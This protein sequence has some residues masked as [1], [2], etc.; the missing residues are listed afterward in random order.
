M[1]TRDGVNDDYSTALDPYS[2][3]RGVRAATNGKT[4]QH[5]ADE[6]DDTDLFAQIAERIESADV[7]AGQPTEEVLWDVDGLMPSD[8][9]PAHMFGPPGAYKSWLGLHLC[10]AIVRGAKFLDR[11]IVRK[12][13]CALYINVDAGPKTFRNRVRR[14]SDSAAFDFISLTSAEFSQLDRRKLFERYRGGFIAID[15]LAAIYNPAKDLDP[16]FAMRQFVDDLRADY[17]QFDCGGVIIDHPHRP[18][19]KGTEGDFYG[20]VQKQAGFRTMWQIS[21]KTGGSDAAENCRTQISCR[22]L[23]EGQDFAAVE[24]VIDFS[25]EPVAFSTTNTEPAS[26]ENAI[27]AKLIA[28]A[29]EQAKTFS[30]TTIEE[31]RLGYRAADVRRAADDLIK[32]GVFVVAGTRGGGHTYRLESVPHPVPDHSVPIENRDGTGWSGFGQGASPSGP[33]ESVPERDGVVE[34]S[35]QPHEQTALARPARRPKTVAA[36]EVLKL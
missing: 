2:G 24:V 25:A 19:E 32:R 31:C 15:C 27:E 28:W 34:N 11:F 7:V 1:A 13:P 14:V 6:S 4:R 18:K 29:G 5:N 33:S 8:D 10:D 17:A 23:S 35:P 3:V 12:R 30:R 16:A 21:K 26:R 20:N 22:K 9:A 36:A